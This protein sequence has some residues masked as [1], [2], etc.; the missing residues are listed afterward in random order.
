VTDIPANRLGRRTSF[1][2]NC[3]QFNLLGNVAM[4]ADCGPHGRLSRQ[5]HRTALL[6]LAHPSARLPTSA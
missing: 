2:D 5:C 3:L 1:A 6:A 4:E